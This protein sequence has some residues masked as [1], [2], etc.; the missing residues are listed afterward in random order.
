MEYL[1]QQR[2]ELLQ[3]ASITMVKLKYC[4]KLN[5]LPYIARCGYTEEERLG[6]FEELDKMWWVAH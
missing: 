1:E 6:I 2:E 5:F 3:Q 4:S